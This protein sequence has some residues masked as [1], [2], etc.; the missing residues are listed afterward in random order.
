M[1]SHPQPREH[2]NE[3]AFYAT[4]VSELGRPLAEAFQ[5]W[6]TEE[7]VV[8]YDGETGMTRS[9]REGRERR[10]HVNAVSR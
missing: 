1:E 9:T 10:S 6:V 5:Q 4:G 3:R 7:E 8:R 2:S